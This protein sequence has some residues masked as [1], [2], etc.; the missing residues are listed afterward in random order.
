MGSVF[1]AIKPISIDGDMRPAEPRRDR[2]QRNFRPRPGR[3]DE[4]GFRRPIAHTLA[5]DRDIAPFRPRPQRLLLQFRLFH[6]PVREAAQKIEIRAAAVVVARPEPHLIAQKQADAPLVDA[7]E[8]QKRLVVGAVH[9]RLAG[10]RPRPDQAEPSSPARLA[11]FGAEV[12]RDRASRGGASL[13]PTLSAGTGSRRR[14]P[15][16]RPAR[17]RRAANRRDRPQSRIP[18]LPPSAAR[19]PNVHNWRC[20]RDRRKAGSTAA[21]NGRG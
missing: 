7:R 20:C 17:L 3:R 9:H 11:A 21:H 15:S 5:L 8:H 13:A 10:R 12:R 6:Q 19:R 1:S 16:A 14:L 18:A 4:K 2:G